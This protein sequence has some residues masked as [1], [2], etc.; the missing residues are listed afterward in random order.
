MKQSIQKF[1]D[2]FPLAD[3]LRFGALGL[4]KR[5]LSNDAILTYSQTGEDRIVMD[6]LAGIR[7]GF[8]VEVGSNDPTHFSNT[9]A[10]Y[11]KGWRGITIDENT[12][13]VEKHRRLRND[14]GYFVDKQY[15]ASTN[16]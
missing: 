14:D 7:N 9:F 16:K 2:R 5:I 11:C 1:F 15:L 10:L 8:Y 6:L 13:L 3:A 12:S 4:V